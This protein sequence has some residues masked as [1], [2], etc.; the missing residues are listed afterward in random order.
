M[1]VHSTMPDAVAILREY[2]RIDTTNP[3]GNELAGARFLG[4]ILDREG[5]PYT[6]FETGRDRANLIARLRGDGTQRPLMLLNHLD[7]VGVERAQWSVD[8]FAGELKDGFVWGRGALDMKGM[9]VMQLMA[10]IR[11]KRAR[12]TLKRDIIFAAVADEEQGGAYGVRWMLENHPEELEAEFVI[13]EGG[14]GVQGM[15]GM[16]A[17]VFS[18]ST[19]E[20]GP[21][22]MHITITGEAGHGSMPPDAHAVHRLVNILH[23]LTR[24]RDRPVFTPETLQLL[25]ALG[26][27]MHQPMIAWLLRHIDRKPV[28]ILLAPV[29]LRKK[30]MRSVLINTASIDI[31]SAGQKEN[32]VPAQAQAVVD[33]R[34]RPDVDP[35]AFARGIKRFLRLREDEVRIP[36]SEPGSRSD[37]DTPLFDAIQRAVR[38]AYPEAV[39]TPS[40]SAGFSDSRF[41]RRRGITAYGIIP[42]VI[43]QKDI[44]RIHGHDERIEVDSFLKGIDILYH[45][46][47][48]LGG[49][50]HR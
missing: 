18:I 8:P 36:Y 38:A 17:P 43:Y 12:C 37:I 39:V 13:N 32:V 33:F 21:L 14:F 3:P 27:N 1:D 11:A 28:Q 24:R 9:A 2:L 26:T 42:I 20:K 35:E 41:F 30:V 10:F 4:N 49:S 6:I 44:D 34:L 22:W 15:P 7:V 46:L 45:I 23:R 50:S 40:L 47:T 19:A 16:N 29:L 48:D 5:I 31:L 25:N